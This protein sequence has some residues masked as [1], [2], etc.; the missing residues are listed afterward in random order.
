MFLKAGVWIGEIP[1]D[2]L[3]FILSKI[4]IKSGLPL[5]LKANA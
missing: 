4:A 1:Q 2:L 5:P 3:A